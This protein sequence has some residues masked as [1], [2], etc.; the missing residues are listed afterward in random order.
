[1]KIPSIGLFV[2]LILASVIRA[3]SFPDYSERTLLLKDSTQTQQIP[4]ITASDGIID[5]LQYYVGP[6]DNLLIS[7]RGVIEQIN[8]IT[9][10][11]E[12]FLVIPKT[13][14]IDL[15]DLTLSEA[16][17]KIINSIQKIYRN[18][19]IHVSL[20]SV[21]KLKINLIGAVN[22]PSSVVLPGNSKL[23]DV[24]SSAEGLDQ[25]A[26]L[27]NIKI[28]NRR[29]EIHLY[30]LIS[31]LR[32]GERSNNP[33][34]REGDVIQIDPSD[35]LVSILGYVKYPGVYEFVENESVK[36]LIDIAGGLLDNARDD[37]IEVSGFLNNNY[38]ISSK[39]YS[40]DFIQ[41]NNIKLNKGDRV[42]IRRKPEYRIDRY[43]TVSGFVKYPGV[44][45]IIKD[46][47]KLSDLLLNEAGGFLE[48]AS[49]PDAFIVRNSGSDEPD[50]E[51]E[52]LKA[53]PRADMNDDEYDY[54]KARSRQKKGKMVVDFYRLFSNKDQSEDLIL[55]EGDE[56]VV[57]EKVDYITLV[58]Q[59]LKPGNIIYKPD[60]SVDQYIDLAGGFGWRAV[61]GDIRV[62]K[63]NTGE[64]LDADDVD[65]LSPGDI[66]WVP[67][68]PPAPKFWDVFQTSLTIL[69]QVATVVAATVA[70]IIS[71]R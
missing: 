44:F 47:T 69:G 60:L 36:H 23:F 5:P 40:L 15:K 49:L 8:N 54:L 12:G 62:I 18:V 16:R 32:V 67:E 24:I 71:V 22:K 21:K 51:F 56:I 68:D 42:I 11:Q 25:N 31:Y 20:T 1:M 45:K 61:K 52:R 34:L 53:I 64:W 4:S 59:V 9:V 29:N 38:T 48:K 33:Y 65:E 2:S 10:N 39:Y 3:Q 55:R 46:K 35:K 41:N 57:P 28:I 27:R 70:V 19:D 6:G 30:D 50:P 14:V 37:T 7:I 63:S 66:I 58:G 43:V 17:E 26:D 13:G